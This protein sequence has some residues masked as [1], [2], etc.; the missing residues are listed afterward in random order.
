MGEEKEKMVFV[1]NPDSEVA[2]GV[3]HEE[4]KG[5]KANVGGEKR[6]KR[7]SRKEND[8]QDVANLPSSPAKAVSSLNPPPKRSPT[9]RPSSSLNNRMAINK[10]KKKRKKGVR[11]SFTVNSPD[12][13]IFEPVKA[14]D[15]T[16]L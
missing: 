14:E 2:I 7:Q 3:N 12:V 15:R 4:R 16:K 11:V 10:K 1:M 13:K 6:L 5:T 9:G 8:I